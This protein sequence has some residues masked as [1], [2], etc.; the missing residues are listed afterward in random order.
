MEDSQAH[1]H[2][3]E[4]IVHLPAPTAWPVVL[5]LGLTFA[6]AGLVTNWGIS[7]MGGVLIV[8]GEAGAKC[9]CSPLGS[10]ASAQR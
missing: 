4:E 5:A 6:L 8:A 2:V 7:V 10:M 1:D 3:S 9:S